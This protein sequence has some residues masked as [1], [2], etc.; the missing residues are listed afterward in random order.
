MTS[1]KKTLQTLLVLLGMTVP[2]LSSAQSSCAISIKSSTD[3][4]RAETYRTQGVRKTVIR[5]L[6]TR[7]DS[8]AAST[9]CVSVDT[10]FVTDTIVVHDTVIVSPPPADTTTPPPAPA[11]PTLTLTTLRDTFYVSPATPSVTALYIVVKDSVGNVI[12]DSL[13]VVFDKTPFFTIEWGAVAR[14]WV[15][16]KATAPGTITGTVTYG[17]ISKNFTLTVLTTPPPADTT[18]PPPADTTT[19]PPPPPPGSIQAP[20][21]PRVWLNYQYP[22]VSRTINV[23]AGGN[24]QAALDSARR[25]D[26]IVLPA[27]A[28]F[29]GNFSL[30]QKSG[31]VADGWIVIRSSNASQLPPRGERVLIADAVNMPKIVSVNTAAAITAES[32]AQGWWISGIEIATT[33]TLNYGL[34]A[35]GVSQG[36]LAAIPTDL[37]LE[38]SYIHGNSTGNL[39]RC[40]LLNSA[41]SVVEDSYLDDCHA[42]GSDAQAIASW[43]GPGPFKIVN[44]TLRGSGE[45]IMFG[46]AQPSIAGMI[47]ADIEIRRNYFH[48]PSSW[49]GVWTKKN[50][51][52]LKSAIRLFVEGNVFDGSWTDAQ[53]GA[54]FVFMSAN[55]SNGAC[56]WCRVTD[57]T[58]RNNLI[59]NVATGIGIAGSQ[60]NTDSA[61]RRVSF[62]SNVID[63]TIYSAGA[64][65]L[66]QAASNVPGIDAV[67]DSLVAVANGSP[68]KQ[69]LGLVN[70]TWINFQFTNIVAS[71]GTYGIFCSGTAS[72]EAALTTCLRGT[73]SYGN[74][75]IIG[76]VKSGYPTSTFIS[77]ESASPLAAAIR[78][79]VSAATAGVERP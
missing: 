57:V 68:V 17:T 7:I 54:A 78:A 74:I 4:Q 36:T 16:S 65:V 60:T 34:V 6:A 67:I 66:V 27:G 71:Y 31:T 37:V 55:Q 76:P 40:V 15:Y 70:G 63:S 25:G 58:V 75:Q 9:V 64:G 24:L 5:R 61:T 79:K 69:L 29:T 73:I 13:P 41:R 62:V 1:M 35:F 8:I 53:I 26:E 42:K 51:F 59:K 39:S 12:T 44:N 47:A 14:R 48:T 49:K 19:P 56:V 46:G 38:R 22:T 20:E 18:T 3:S 77:S 10:V 43:N 33:A 52:E 72:G 21:L 30:K 50:L 11:S 23:P 2:A 28:V 32:Y 45:N